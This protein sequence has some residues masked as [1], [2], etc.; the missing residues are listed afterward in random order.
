MTYEESQKIIASLMKSRV[1]TM[2]GSAIHIAIEN[3]SSID[4]I[5]GYVKKSLKDNK[6]MTIQ[7]LGDAYEE[8][9]ELLK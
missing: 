9:K 6:A 2:I 1:H 8:L 7:C 4:E 5:L 3:G